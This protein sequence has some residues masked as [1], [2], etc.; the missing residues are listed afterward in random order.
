MKIADSFRIIPIALALCAI[1]SLPAGAQQQ[2]DDP[3]TYLFDTVAPLPEAVTGPVPGTGWKPV[4]EGDLTHAFAGDAVFLNNKIAVVLRK[5]GTG[6]EVYSRVAQGLVRR[7]VVAPCGR[8]GAPPPRLSSS[9]VK[10][11]SRSAMG[12]DAAF[13]A[14][15][16]DAASVTFRLTTGDVML[17]VLPGKGTDR[18]GLRCETAYVVVPDFFG[19]DI[20]YGAEALGD[21]TVG[22][23][24]ENFFLNLIEGGD[25]I[26]M[27]V[28]Q[29]NA[30]N[31]DVHFAGKAAITQI[32]CASG[33]K[34][35]VACLE[36]PKIWH[37]RGLSEKDAQ[38][39]IVLDWQPPFA[40]KWRG[41]FVR[42]SGVAESWAFEEEQIADFISPV[43]GKIPYPCRLDG[44]RAIVC[45]PPSRGEE[46]ERLVVYPIDR[47]RAT[48]LSAF[49]PIDIL[50]NTLGVGPCQYILALEGVAGDAPPTPAQVTEWVERQVERKRAARMADQIR[51]RLAQMTQHIEHMDARIG[52]Y[53]RLAQEI[54]TMCK[55]P[56]KPGD[57]TGLAARLG[58]IAQEMEKDIAQRRSDQNALESAKRL[59]DDLVALLGKGGFLEDCRGLGEQLRRI[60]AVQDNTLAKCRMAVRRMKQECRMVPASPLA[61]DVRRRVEQMLKAK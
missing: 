28:W 51:E 53:A 41:D 55:A 7:V 33:Q 15:D 50:R 40:A 25:A 34:I 39:D 9:A 59:A 54:Q 57:N 47:S 4:A 8:E 36:G 45:L 13:G 61:E 35:W 38:A 48:P 42:R 60:G 10:E 27:C 5:A 6:V 14:Q 19:D 22:L 26:V 17:E 58:A 56:E 32:E 44:G 11:N 1:P 16:G 37:S 3:C 2:A 23:P 29:S 12:I 20:V 49:C 21:R 52:E 43:H 31:A 18:L 30:Q 24:A 46:A